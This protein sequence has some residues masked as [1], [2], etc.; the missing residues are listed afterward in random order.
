MKSKMN[1][2]AI[3]LSFMLVLSVAISKTA[4]GQEISW[5][6]DSVFYSE[7]DSSGFVSTEPEDALGFI[8]DAKDEKV[9]FTKRDI[10]Y[11]SIKRDHEVKLRDKFTVFHTS[12]RIN[13]PVSGNKFGY[14][15]HILGELQVSYIDG[16]LFV[17]EITKT[18][19]VISIGDKIS[20]YKPR[21]KNIKLTKSETEIEGYII[22]TRDQKNAISE[23]CIVYID[24][25][26]ADGVR[27]GNSFNV[28]EEGKKIHDPTT[29]REI[30][31][32]PSVIGGGIILFAR[33]HTSTALITHS[34]RTLSIGDKI[35]ITQK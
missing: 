1:R 10:V 31:L 35:Q 24:K 7:I 8:V 3:L 13:H 27:K 18:Y 15:N 25:G 30:Q 19:D 26:E 21:D 6:G 11:L 20:L 28:L 12:E 16:E 9:M 22:Q 23:K 5:S 14:V 29:D 2:A 4:I 33:M 34:N 32:S 17:A